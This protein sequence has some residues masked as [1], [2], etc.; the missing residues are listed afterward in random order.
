M[1]VRERPE[2]TDGWVMRRLREAFW[3]ALVAIVFL[4]AAWCLL[5][6]HAVTQNMIYYGV[7]FSTGR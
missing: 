1:G 6:G 7:P 4:Y 2:Q 5:V 3:R